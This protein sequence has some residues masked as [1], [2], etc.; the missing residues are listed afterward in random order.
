[1]DLLGTLCPS[2]RSAMGILWLILRVL[3]F[4]APLRRSGARG[5][6]ALHCA[7]PRNQVRLLI[8]APARS[9]HATCRHHPSN[10]ETTTKRHPKCIEDATKVHPTSA[11]IADYQGRWV[12]MR[13]HNDHANG[14]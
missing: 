5:T 3:R 7:S 1:M 4:A 6:A 10:I 14:A 9:I 13:D 8:A 12:T 2:A 11:T